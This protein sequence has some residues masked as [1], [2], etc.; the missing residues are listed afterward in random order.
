MGTE[1]DNKNGTMDGLQIK[2]YLMQ[3]PNFLMDYPELLPLLQLPKEWQQAE[4]DSNIIDFRS[5]LIG[6]LQHQLN[7]TDQEN[8]QLFSVVALNHDYQQ[9]IYQLILLF[10]QCDNLFSLLKLLSQKMPQILQLNKIVLCVVPNPAYE[11]SLQDI[12]FDNLRNVDVKFLQLFAEDEVLQRE[13]ITG[14]H[15]IYGADTIGSDL[16]VAMDFYKCRAFIAYGADA[17]D[18]F[19]EN[20]STDLMVFLTK[21]FAATIKLLARIHDSGMPQP[22]MDENMRGDTMMDYHKE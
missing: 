18:H 16:L 19:T 11:K 5:A 21:S 9:R 8:H 17:S 14:E 22:V 1:Q 4:S 12:Y 3:N 7:I 13:N 10:L 15:E 6:N 20:L 2:Q